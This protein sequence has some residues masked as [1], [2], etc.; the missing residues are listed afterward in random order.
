M[1]D[2]PKGQRTSCADCSKHAAVQAAL[3]LAGPDAIACM[4]SEAK[5]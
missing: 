4:H 1:I 2:Q 3:M 5:S